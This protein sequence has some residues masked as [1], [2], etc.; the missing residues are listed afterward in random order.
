[1]LLLS[2]IALVL[3]AV[4]ETVQNLRSAPVGYEDETGFHQGNAPESEF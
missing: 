4:T 2:V 3:I 1:M